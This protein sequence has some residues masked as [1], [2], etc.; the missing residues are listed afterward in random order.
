MKN[1]ANKKVSP[2]GIK[3]IIILTVVSA[4]FIIGTAISFN[5]YAENLKIQEAVDNG[6]IVEAE[7]TYLHTYRKSNYSIMC[8]YVDENGIVYECDCARGSLKNYEQYEKD[9]QRIGEKVEIYKG[10][11]YRGKGV[12]WAVSYG[13]DVKAWDALAFGIV[14]ASLLGILFLLLTLYLLYFYVPFKNKNKK[15]V[16]ADIPKM[17]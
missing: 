4:V 6:I 11:V 15:N 7:I 1:S 17:Q 14:F 5:A 12:C 8:R 9:K 10:N 2:L 16:E 3:A 13:K